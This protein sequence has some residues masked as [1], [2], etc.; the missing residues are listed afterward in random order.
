[1]TRK[2]MIAA[3]TIAMAAGATAAFAATE[4]DTDGDGMYS[5]S[6]MLAVLPTLTEETFMSVDGNA[7]GMIDDTELAAAQEA[8]LIPADIQG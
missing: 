3:T 8:G 2:F 6:E 4:I 7:D 5:F 1:M